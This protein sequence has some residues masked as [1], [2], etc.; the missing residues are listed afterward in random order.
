M[1]VGSLAEAL[2]IDTSHYFLLL[3]H[4]ILQLDAMSTV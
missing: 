1:S 2:R 3:F 4:A